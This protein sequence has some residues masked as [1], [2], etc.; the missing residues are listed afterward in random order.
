MQQEPLGAI[1]GFGVFGDITEGIDA[2]IGRPGLAW[3]HFREG[4]EAGARTS[5]GKREW[6]GFVEG[7]EHASAVLLGTKDRAAIGV[8]AE[9]AAI[10]V[11]HSAAGR[12]GA[13]VQRGAALIGI[14]AVPAIDTEEFSVAGAHLKPQTFVAVPVMVGMRS[15]TQ[16]SGSVIM[17]NL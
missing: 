17:R 7:F 1:D 8:G 16:A 6:R 5:D 4:F 12:S 3:R 9:Q 10:T 14:V 13:Q 15:V 11:E 2:L